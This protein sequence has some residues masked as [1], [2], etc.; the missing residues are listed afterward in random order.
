M[1]TWLRIPAGVVYD[2]SCWNLCVAQECHCMLFLVPGT[3]FAGADQV[4]H[5]LLLPVGLFD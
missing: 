3:D 5:P 1:T 2:C 4:C